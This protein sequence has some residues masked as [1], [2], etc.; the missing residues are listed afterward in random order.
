MKLPHVS[1]RL[2]P[3]LVVASL[4]QCHVSAQESFRVELGKDGETLRDMRPVFLT[5]ETRPLPAI[6]PAEVAR[7]YQKL[8]EDSDEPEVRI[9]A[10]NR[11]NNIRDRSGQ[12]IGFSQAREA[13]IYQE[14]LGSY[15]SILSRGSFSGRLDELLYQMA[16]AHSLTGQHQES[17]Q[18]LRQLVGLYPQSVLVPEARFR[19]AEA[20]FSA[21]R[22]Q[23]AERGYQALI[24]AK[25][26]S[27]L[28]TKASYMLG[29]SQF[30]QGDSGWE[31]AASTFMQLLDQQ[32]P[33]SVQEQ[34]PVT[35][36]LN[37]IED[38][39]RI[40][41]LMASRMTDHQTLERWL[42]GRNQSQWFY[43]LYDRLADL[44]AIEGRYDQAV[45]VNNAFVRAHSEHESKPDFL[46]Q[47]VEFWKRAGELEPVRRAKAEFVEQYVSEERYRNLSDLH[48][49]HWQTYG[50]SLADHYYAAGSTYQSGGEPQEAKRSWAKAAEYYEVLAPRSV[51]EGELMHLAGDARLLAEQDVQAL[52]NFRRAAYGADY[53]QAR[54]AGWAA[55]TLLRSA[56]PPVTH[57]P[58]PDD[59]QKALARLSSEEQRYS[60]T[61]GTDDRVSALRAD[62]GNRWYA[63]GDYERA[64]SYAK[65][66]LDWESPSTEQQYAAWLII[67]RVQQHKAEFGL[68]ERAWRQAIT[69][70][71]TERHL[72]VSPTERNDLR[73]QLAVAIY[74]QGEQ[75]ASVG[76]S[77]LAVAHF[78]RVVNVLPGSEL[79]IKSRFDA[80]N[81]LLKSSEWLGAINELKQFRSDYPNHALTDQI[82]EKLVLSY[83]QSQQPLKA[84]DELLA[85]A[86]QLAEPWSHRLRAAAIYHEA[87]KT[88]RRD[89]LY[90]EW[91]SVAPTAVSAS[92]HVQQQTMRHRLIES[93]ASD[94]ETL[95]ELVATESRSQW[96]SEET[97]VWAADAA[98]RL[99]A[100]AADNFAAIALVHPLEETL[101][102]KQAA[103][104]R[105]QN[106]LLDAESFAGEKV[107]TEVLFRRAELYRVLAAD[108]MASEVP[109]ELNELETMQYQML[110]EEEAYPLEE[111]A[112]EL[113]TQNH[114]KI[115]QQGYDTWIGQSLEAL[116][117]MHPGRYSRN[118]RW[119]TWAAQEND[120][121]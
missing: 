102:R 26:D 106:Y 92:E 67:A 18:R 74:K 24:S 119:M 13:E 69:L 42:A 82:S 35:S 121:V 105:A 52:A 8:F 45:A 79:A 46:V 62:L 108:L 114:Q 72:A 43:L 28:A 60:G 38:S 36:N 32:L 29:W 33:G 2:L 100:R 51:V 37:M 120:G 25:P 12:D 40:L 16:K 21:G 70:A 111:R 81:T 77:T 48:R 55:I 47:N 23:E 9:D 101:V 80:A 71:E 88:D 96:H 34:Q 57:G 109:S 22:Y 66:T 53:E 95:Q 39:F 84:A 83:R 110:L 50:R 103:L 91:L 1:K 20:E 87:G 61:F 27:E 65:K 104:E 41:A 31:K 11:L 58:K 107:A 90:R 113:H 5:F 78:K 86:A 118:L 3:W 93:G 112:L 85:S 76:N 63:H 56:L 99:G 7:R 30:K 68:A 19:I 17:I 54:D 44:H 6:S 4:G 98:L 73:E 64:L 10:L 14:I 97:L 116:A 49:Q 115:K 59:A 75:A 15:E 89:R 94:S 117:A